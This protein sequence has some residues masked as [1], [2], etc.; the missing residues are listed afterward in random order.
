M[1]LH[2]NSTLIFRLEELKNVL[3]G[4][5]NKPKPE[6]NQNKT[7]RKN[8]ER[9]LNRRL[10]RPDA[11]NEAD[12]DSNCSSLASSTMFDKLRWKSVHSIGY[13]NEYEFA[14]VD[15]S[16]IEDKDIPSKIVT[17]I[18]GYS[19]QEQNTS[20]GENTDFLPMDASDSDAELEQNMRQEVEAISR[21]ICR[22]FGEYQL[23]SFSDIDAS[24]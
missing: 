2:F 21:D 6:Q 18:P 14:S 1:S 10:P 19:K 16:D 17:E 24:N 4:F 3:R 5:G 12:I 9:F 13:E 23:A 7:S 11:G 20:V 8:T 15:A 22:N